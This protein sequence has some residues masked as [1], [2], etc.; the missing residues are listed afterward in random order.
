M[1]TLGRFSYNSGLLG[2]LQAPL[3]STNIIKYNKLTLDVNEFVKA[4]HHG[5]VSRQLY[6]PTSHLMFPG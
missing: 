6:I 3:T 1:A 4:P 2:F 5:L